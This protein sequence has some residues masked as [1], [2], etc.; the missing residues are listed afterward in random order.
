MTDVRVCVGGK[1]IYLGTS[2]YPKLKAAKRPSE[3]F[4]N[5]IHR[6]LGA[7]GPSFSDFRDVV[8]KRAADELADV[9]DKMRKEA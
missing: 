5:V 4:S 3:S 2:A 9:T 6:I 7:K 8:D 1:K